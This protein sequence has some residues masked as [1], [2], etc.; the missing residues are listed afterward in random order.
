MIKA[1]QDTYNSRPFSDLCGRQITVDIVGTRCVYLNN[2]RIAGGKPY[3]SENIPSRSMNLTVREAL[4]AFTE[5]EL[6]A[7]L[8][9]RREQNAYCA[10][11]R[12]YRDKLE[13]MET[14]DAE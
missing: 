8:F 5:A 11:A 14:R 9:E 1:W 12:N 2:H 4:A 10:G 13:A 3:V 6:L 7:Y